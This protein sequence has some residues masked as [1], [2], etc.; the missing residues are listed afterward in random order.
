MEHYLCSSRK[1]E[2]RRN[3]KED[4]HKNLNSSHDEAEAPLFLNFPSPFFDEISNIPTLE[5]KHNHEQHQPLSISEPSP[6]ASESKHLKKR[7]VGKKDRHSK[8]HTAQGLRDRRMRLS[9][10]IA[11]KFFDLQDLLGFDKASK[12]IEW[13]FC[14][15]NK[16]IKEVAEN[17]NPQKTN[18]SF[19]NNIKNER[20]ISVAM[21]KLDNSKEEEIE[22]T[23]SRKQIQNTYSIRETRDQARA[24]ARDR[25][26][27][28]VMIKELEKSNQ[29]FIR[30]PNDE[31]HKLGLGYLGSPNNHNIVEELGYTSGPSEP[32]QQES[33]S[34]SH[35]HSS[36]PHLLRDLQSATVDVNSF[37]KYSGSTVGT[38]T[39]CSTLIDNNPSA[40]WLNSNNGFLGM[41][42]EWDADSF[43]T[44]QYCNYGIVPSTDIYEQ[45]PSSF[46]MSTTNIL[47]LQSQNQGK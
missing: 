5:N 43:L 27:K 46:F 44:D 33:S 17:F 22:N 2:C 26:R 20:S 13:L 1:D 40:G 19:C 28:R 6:L 42:G 12:T 30:N 21:N 47:H 39:Y 16:A 18:Q 45:N 4:H 24:R 10:N 38:S 14:K 31:F 29:M 37:G 3:M 8:I 34:Y 41:P 11:R 7:N 23:E 9:L 36:T 15:S 25:T 35:E 32:I